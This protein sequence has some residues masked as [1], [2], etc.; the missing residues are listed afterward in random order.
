MPAGS[1]VR[2]GRLIVGCAAVA[3]VPGLVMVLNTPRMYRAAA[4]IQLETPGSTATDAAA[5]AIAVLTSRSLAREVAD[6]LG[7]R[8]GVAMA[9]RAELVRTNAVVTQPDS[10]AGVLL[11]SWRG[12]DPRLARDV[13]NL[14][15][16]SYVRRTTATD[17]MRRRGGMAALKQ[18]LDVLT[19][20]ARERDRATDAYVRRHATV[21]AGAE[22]RRRSAELERLAGLRAA[23]AD[24]RD[25]LAATLNSIVNDDIGDDVGDVERVFSTAPFMRAQSAIGSAAGLQARLH[26]Q[27]DRRTDLLARLDPRDPAV[28]SVQQQIAATRRDVRAVAEG[29]VAGMSEQVR[30]YDGQMD[31][32]RRGAAGLPAEQNELTRLQRQQ[33]RAEELVARMRERLADASIVAVTEAPPAQ[34]LDAAELPSAP[35]DASRA[36]VLMLWLVT[37]LAVGVAVAVLRDHFEP[38]SVRGYSSLYEAGV[39]VGRQIEPQRPVSLQHESCTRR[40]C[41]SPASRTPHSRLYPLRGRQPA[42]DR[43]VRAGL[44]RGAG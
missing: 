40:W 29:Y 8:L 14:L 1:L 9:D 15:A 43:S 11:V 5:T 28:K 32:I 26:E 3:L 10:R 16:S 34:L 41:D 19:A 37:G 35:A 25:L 17:S 31:A 39:T 21:D 33:Q 23:T 44:R 24:D 18:Q 30:R 12:A 4:S 2:N 20:E 22:G 27:Q 36:A 38:A 42:H 13:A 7:D 6:S